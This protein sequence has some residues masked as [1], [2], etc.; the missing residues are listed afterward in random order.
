MVTLIVP[1][2]KLSNFNDR[3]LA[4]VSCAVWQLPRNC[5]DIEYGRIQEYFARSESSDVVIERTSRVMSLFL[6][7]CIVDLFHIQIMNIYDGMLH[8]KI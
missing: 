2:H 6:L 8:S 1:Y 3:N 5:D 7:C 4:S